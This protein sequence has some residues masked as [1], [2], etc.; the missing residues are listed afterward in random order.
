MARKLTTD[1]LIRD[2]FG[3]DVRK[4]DIFITKNESSITYVRKLINQLEES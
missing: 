1:E 3:I 4:E 2:I